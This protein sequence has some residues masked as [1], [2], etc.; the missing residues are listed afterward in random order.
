MMQTNSGGGMLGPT[1]VINGHVAGTWK[2]MLRKDSVV[3]TPHWFASPKK[4]DHHAF[5]AAAQ[6]YG[7]FLG[8][9]A[10]L[11]SVGGVRTYKCWPRMTS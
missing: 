8:L 4:S 1:I 3:I 9:P 2:R 6:H 7:A 10:V 5:A 11:A